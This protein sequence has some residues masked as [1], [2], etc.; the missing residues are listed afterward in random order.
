MKED[1]KPFILLTND[2]GISAPGLQALHEALS[3]MADLMVVAPSGEMSAVGHAI[4]LSDPLRVWEFEKDG[5][6]FGY[7]VKGTPA[8]C[9]KVA[10][11][12]LLNGRRKW[13]VVISGINHGANTGID[14]IYSG[15]VSAAT[16]GAILGIPSFAISVAT[17]RKPDFSVAVDF[18]RKMVN[19]ILDH[20]LPAGVYLNINVP[21]L[22]R[23]EIRGVRLT[24]QSLAVYEERYEVRRDPRNRVY[25]WLAGEK[26]GVES[27]DE[28]DEQA[29]RQGFISVTPLH[30][31]LTSYEALRELRSWSLVP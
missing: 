8:D 29:I 24:R 19:W 23:E 17:F 9:V 12:A 25:Y 22:P 31:D 21:P 28:V 16:E 26:V 11:W 10:Y 6:F 30:Y 3:D 5:R 7:A 1:R 14:I 4:T 18:A 20:G 15:T 2:D 27:D 13:D